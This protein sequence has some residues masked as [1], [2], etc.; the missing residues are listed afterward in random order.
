[1]TFVADSETEFNQEHGPFALGVTVK[2]HFAV[3]ADGVNHAREI[4][5]KFANDD[6]GHDDDGNGSLEGAE[7]HA[8]GLIEQ[9]PA[10]LSGQWIVA[11]V[12]YT[13]TDQTE[14]AQN[15][16]PFAVGVRVKVAYF[17]DTQGGRVARAIESTN[18]DGGA[19]VEAHFTLFGFVDDM[20]PGGFIGQWLVDNIAFVAGAGSQFKEA[21]GL[22][23][24]GAFVKVEYS[25]QNG[26][27]QIQEI[28]THVPPGAGDHTAIGT[29]DDRSGSAIQ[30]AGVNATVWVIGGASYTVTPATT[31]NDVQGALAIGQTA[32]VN[33]YTA[34]DGSQVATEIRGVTLDH[35]LHLP[36]VTR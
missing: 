17:L 15:D 16:A 28:E 12:T 2:V 36:L 10:N 13:A 32:L 9:F 33:S 3:G 19:S 35:T 21:H 30:A 5:T 23:G 26:S 25:I 11:G 34:G 4:E 27:K 1:M 7:G 29:I 14:F 24:L 22:L 31:F 8:Y 6:D 18:E 20:P